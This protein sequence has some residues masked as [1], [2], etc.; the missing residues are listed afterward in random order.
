MPKRFHTI[1]L[2]AFVVRR[3]G[4][5]FTRHPGAT[6]TYTL[7]FPDREPRGPFTRQELL[8]YANHNL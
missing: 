5:Q 2:V 7:Q 1:K 6:P 3:D 4:G 8:T